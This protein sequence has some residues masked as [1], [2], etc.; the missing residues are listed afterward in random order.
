M[1]HEGGDDFFLLTGPE[2]VEAVTNYICTEFDKQVKELY[3]AE[4]QAQGYIVSKDREGTE[5]RFP[6]M[7]ISLAGVTNM[8]RKLTSYAEVTNICAEVKK[9]VKNLTKEGG[10]SIFYLDRRT[11]EERNPAPT[12]EAH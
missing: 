11:G 3:S 2:K 6:I 7:T 8:H 10:K 5:K 12:Q 4:D 1:G 9:K